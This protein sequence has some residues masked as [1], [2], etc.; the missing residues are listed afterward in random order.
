MLHPPS[1]PDCDNRKRIKLNNFAVNNTHSIHC[2]NSYIKKFV[3]FL[4]VLMQNY[5][6]MLNEKTWYLF[7]NKEPFTK[8]YA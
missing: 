1:L 4:E 3:D 7:Q 5:S 8:Y 2:K 6:N